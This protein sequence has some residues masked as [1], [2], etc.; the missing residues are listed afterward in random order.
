MHTSR[1]LRLALAV[2][3]G[4][5][6]TL[7]TASPAPA[8]TT[9]TANKA[10][11]WL[12]GQMTANGHHLNSGFVDD[13]DQFQ[14]FPDTGLTIDA[15][16]AVKG[17][18]RSNDTEAKATTAWVIDNASDYVSGANTGDA[19]DSRYAG[20]LGKLLLFVKATGQSGSTF[21]GI[22]VESDLRGL[23]DS[24]GRFPDRSD[25][26]D[27]SNGVGHAFDVLGLA[28]TESG[29]PAKAVEFLLLQQCPNGGFRVEL[30]TT[31]CADNAKANLDATSFAVMALSEVN[32][33]AT[34]DTAFDK[35]VAYVAGL[36]KAN[37]SFADNANSTGLAATTLRA[38]G[39]APRANRAASFVKTLQLTSGANAG[40]ILVDEDSYDAAV[41][42]GLDTQGK[43]LAARATAQAVLALGLPAYSLLGETE[44]VEPATSE[45]LSSSSVPEGGSLTVTGGGFASGEKVNVV[46]SSDPVTVGQPTANSSGGVSLTFTLPSSVTAGSHTVT[47]TGVTSGATVSSP[48]TVTAAPAA[49]TSTTSTTAVRATI[50]RTGADDAT[51]QAM[52]AGGLL[53][54]GGAMVLS[55]RRRRI[56]YPF[57]K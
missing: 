52:L 49:S 24:T 25:F 33:S 42:D 48:F 30:A 6:L 5:T 20:A 28:R 15:L 34:I 41:A 54:I 23:M 2:G 40:A 19:A 45:T 51:G 14:Q 56:V 21:D 11:D 8:A 38:A 9:A 50:V 32:T 1:I 47:L 35:G 39:D 4:A 37:S 17:A 27:F 53:V 55:T 29:V 57:K 31:Q 10:I 16:L 3:A 12:E 18:G 7:A 44:A 43:T 22:N 13:Q 36:Q 46:V 26:G